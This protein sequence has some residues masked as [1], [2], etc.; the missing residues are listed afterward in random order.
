MNPATG[1]D[2]ERETGQ[3]SAQEGQNIYTYSAYCQGPK[4]KAEQTNITHSGAFYRYAGIK[5][6]EECPEESV[7]GQMGLSFYKITYWTK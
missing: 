7:R 3:H 6:I 1:K 4:T 2:F 5:K